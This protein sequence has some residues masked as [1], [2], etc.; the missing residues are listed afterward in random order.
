MKNIH[1]TN[2]VI[3]KP[4]DVVWGWL[5]E[6]SKYALLYP[7]WVTKVVKVDTDKYEITDIRN[8]K[9]LFTLIADKEKGSII[10]KIGDE[11]S[12]TKLFS[13]N[14]GTAVV[15]IGTRWKKMKNPLFWF[16]FKKGVDKDFKNAKRVIESTP[17][18]YIT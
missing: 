11:T 18:N 7:N 5:S 4:Y 10:L 3:E 15:H 9:S 13:F 1:F 6:P 8:Q 2:V 12:C 17:P 16:L 14:N